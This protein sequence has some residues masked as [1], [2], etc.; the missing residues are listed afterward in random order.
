MAASVLAPGMPRPLL[1]AFLWTLLACWAGTVLWLSS[2]TPG[3]LPEAA[4]M[5]SDKV[6]HFIAFAVGG[7]LAAAALRLS[8][9]Q[10]PRARLIIACIV[11]VAVFGAVDE[12]LQIFTPG[13]TGGDIYDWIADFLGAVAGALL[14][15]PTHARLE[16][17]IARP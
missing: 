4:F 8:R 13:R 3:E 5:V 12:G 17:F 10:T 2:L 7:W 1:S 6:N 14:T 11:L 15:I 16:R 9:P